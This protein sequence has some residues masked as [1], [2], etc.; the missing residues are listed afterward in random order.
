MIPELILTS[1][2]GCKAVDGKSDEYGYNINHALRAVSFAYCFKVDVKPEDAFNVLSHDYVMGK[3]VNAKYKVIDDVLK[4]YGSSLKHFF[5]HIGVGPWEGGCIVCRLV[6]VKEV[7]K[8]I[9][10]C[11]L[12]S[13]HFDNWLD[14][15]EVLC[16]KL[17]ADVSLDDAHAGNG[18]RRVLSPI[19]F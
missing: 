7:K 4:R 12:P 18:I 9:R 6:D 1:V 2:H 15:L 11:V 16:P 13:L 8:V 19:L 10:T 14:A 5:H 3:E 17:F